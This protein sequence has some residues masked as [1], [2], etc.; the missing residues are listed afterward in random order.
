MDARVTTKLIQDK[1]AQI[2]R[3]Q[4]TKSATSVND[5]GSSASLNNQAETSV[6]VSQASSSSV[7]MQPQSQTGVTGAQ[8]D[9]LPITS[10]STKTLSTD[11]G[12]GEVSSG[13]AADITSLVQSA[14]VAAPASE[15]G[16]HDSKLANN[17]APPA[18]LTVLDTDPSAITPTSSSSTSNTSSATSRSEVC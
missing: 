13:A 9:Q 12:I 5:G 10:N 2:Q 7:S 3:Q 1:V 11:S 17:D 6:T 15:N 16:T 14:G 4:A 18:A 8:V